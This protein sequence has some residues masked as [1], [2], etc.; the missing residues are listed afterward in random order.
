MLE[1]CVVCKRII[2]Q[3]RHFTS[4]PVKDYL[5]ESGYLEKSHKKDNP[6]PL[7]VKCLS[8]IEKKINK[9]Y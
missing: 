6:L 5:I 4:I 3:P 7:C 2:I 8:T 1:R 9:L